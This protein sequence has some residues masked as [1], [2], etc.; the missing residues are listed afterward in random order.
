MD[1]VTQ[2]RTGKEGVEWEGGSARNGVSVN[3]QA[4]TT[5]RTFARI[6]RANSSRQREMALTLIICAA[7]IWSHIMCCNMC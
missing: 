4:K 5:T 7:V 2:R 3:T 1:K 6:V